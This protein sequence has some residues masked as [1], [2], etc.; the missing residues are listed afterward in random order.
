MLEVSRILREQPW[1]RYCNLYGVSDRLL[2]TSKVFMAYNVITGG[3]E[4]HSL[5]SF[6]CS[7]CQ[8]VIPKEYVN[9]FLPKDFRAN[10]HRRNVDELQH[11]REMSAYLYDRAEQQRSKILSTEGLKVIER[12]LGRAL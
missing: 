7:S 10:E 12:T 4:L 1:L 9:G 11:Q 3:Y 6:G 2:E 5:H 8:S